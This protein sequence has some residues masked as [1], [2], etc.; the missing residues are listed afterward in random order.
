MA[1]TEKSVLLDQVEMWS[2]Y[3][4]LVSGLVSVLTSLSGN[5]LIAYVALGILGLIVGEHCIRVIFQKSPMEQ[6]YQVLLPSSVAQRG[7]LVYRY[8][9][10]ERRKAI[11]W[12]AGLTVLLVG[13]GGFNLWQAL[14]PPVPPAREGETLILVVQFSTDVSAELKYDYAQLIYDDLIDAFHETDIRI[15]KV[16]NLRVASPESARKLGQRTGAVLVIWGKFDNAFVFPR[17]EV[18][19]GGDQISQLDPGHTPLKKENEYLEFTL[20][21]EITQG[22]IYMTE[23]TIG[24]IYYLAHKYENALDYFNSA[25]ITLEK[26]GILNLEL[27]ETLNWK[28][29]YVYFYRANTF[30]NLGALP[31]AMLDYRLAIQKNPK[32]TEAYNNLGV[33][34]SMLGDSDRAIE[35]F[36]L[37]IKTGGLAI[38]YYN[39]GS[40]YYHQENFQRAVSDY[41]QAVDAESQNPTFY[42]ARA[43]GYFFLCEYGQ[44]RDDLT[45]AIELLKG[46]PEGR[47]RA[48]TNRGI[49]NTRLADYVNAV[50]DY[51]MALDLDSNLAP[52]HYNLAA[53]Y[54][55]MDETDTAVE[56]LTKAVQLD[57]NLRNKVACDLDFDGIRDLPQIS[58]YPLPEEGCEPI[59]CP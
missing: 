16:D 27:S 39:R 29:E 49:A 58:A 46:D 4:G 1:N 56:A 41:S 8:P 54:A 14:R 37:A 55:L 17:Y 23:F 6:A 7:E 15:E 11:I 26:S 5:P 24:Q 9:T 18:I 28:E 48:L 22:M 19:S 35:Q 25:F 3:L 2:R 59:V 32:F 40:I 20:G 42:Q 50:Q 45:K 38:A 47:A 31:Q 36:D 13:V 30:T 43:D 21:T 57:Q 33:G 53:T 52:A 10:A 44:A 34:Y 12:L 51:E